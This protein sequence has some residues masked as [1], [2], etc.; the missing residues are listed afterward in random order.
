M[1]I[2]EVIDLIGQLE[3]G[4]DIE[5]LIE[6]PDLYTYRMSGEESGSFTSCIYKETGQK[7]YIS[8]FDLDLEKAERII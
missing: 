3:P 8:I 5:S 2:E 7:D 6:F 1:S 4:R